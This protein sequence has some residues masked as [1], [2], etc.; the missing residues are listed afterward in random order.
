[1]ATSWGEDLAHLWT[2]APAHPL[3]QTRLHASAVGEPKTCTEEELAA[4]MRLRDCIP[5][6]P[7]VR[8]I[9]RS[10]I[11]FE[12]CRTPLDEELVETS[13]DSQFYFENLAMPRLHALPQQNEHWERWFSNLV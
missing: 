8:S 11:T 7:M 13:P 1:M 2:Q 9:A 5:N 12:A 3:Q 10:H 4:A 6:I